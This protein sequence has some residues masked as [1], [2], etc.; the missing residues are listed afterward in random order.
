VATEDDDPE[1]SSVSDENCFDE[2]GAEQGA[3]LSGATSRGWAR[4]EIMAL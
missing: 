4:R 1:D 3:L 2:F